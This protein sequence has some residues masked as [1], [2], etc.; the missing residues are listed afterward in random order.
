MPVLAQDS[1][2]IA[3]PFAWLGASVARRCPP[4]AVRFEKCRSKAGVKPSFG[5][6]TASSNDGNKQL[7]VLDWLCEAF[8]AAPSALQVL[9]NCGS[10][11]QLH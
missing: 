10:V 4:A 7:A 6:G 1:W 11:A 5:E 2:E 3:G 8:T 9:W